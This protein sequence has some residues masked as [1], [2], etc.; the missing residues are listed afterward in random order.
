MAS[1]TIVMESQM[2]TAQTLVAEVPAQQHATIPVTMAWADYCAFGSDCSDCGPRVDADGD[3][4]EDDPQ[5]LGLGLYS[6]CND[7][8]STINSSATDIPNDGI[9]QDCDGSDAGGSSTVAEICSDGIDNDGDGLTDC[10][11]SDCAGDPACVG[12]NS[13]CYT[14]NMSDSYGDGW[15]GATVVAN[16]NG[17]QIGA[18][19]ISGSNGSFATEAICISDAS[20]LELSWNSGSFDDEIFFDLIHPDGTTVYTATAGN[21]PTN[22]PLSTGSLYTETVACSGYNGSGSTSGGSTS[23]GSCTY[24]IEMLCGNDGWGDADLISWLDGSYNHLHYPSFSSCSADP[25]HSETD[26]ITTTSA[27][28]LSL[29]YSYTGSGTPADIG[30]YVTGDSTGTYTGGS[31]ATTTWS[32]THTCP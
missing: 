30:I 27:E 28:V 2:M 6:D 17:S 11:D 5:N 29:D 13:C 16:E 8:D 18:Y 25:T 24:N 12:A 1:M 3:L 31:G 21:T 23:G 19:D 14:L 15:N 7:S 32:A 20:D 26:I 22:G 9:D 4:H 10:S